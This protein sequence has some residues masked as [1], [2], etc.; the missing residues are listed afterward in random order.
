METT[1]SSDVS[2][3]AGLSLEELE[4]ELASFAAHLAAGMCRWLAVVAEL[5]RR[6]GSTAWRSSAEWIA[7]RCA[8]TPRAAREHVRV[9]RALP[10]LPAIREAFARGELSYAKV[11]ALTRVATAESEAGLLPLAEV[12]TAAQ[13]ER[14]LRVYRRVSTREAREL[15][16]YEELIWY[17]DED[18]ALVIRGRLAPED[19]ALFLKALEA[20]RERLW[21]S[22]Q[23][24]EER[25]SAEPPPDDPPHRPS[26]VDAL[27]ALSD[28]AL[29]LEAGRTGGDRYQVV[30]HIEQTALSGEAG[31]GGCMLDDGPA[32][33]PE[34]ARRLACDAAVVTLY[35]RA[36]EPLSVG[37][38]TRTI[39]PALRRALLTRDHGCRFPGC[40][41]H[42]Y[43]DAHH[44]QHWAQGG[45]TAL[46]NLLL[47]CRRH[48]RLLHEGGYTVDHQLRFHDPWGNEIPP[49]P[50]LP[51][52]SADALRS[53]TA[54]LDITADTCRNGHGDP[55]DLALTI[56]AMQKTGSRD[57][58]GTLEVG[59]AGSALGSD[60][61]GH[62]EREHVHAA[63]TC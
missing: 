20:S 43:V 26:N 27:V 14:A 41:N 51:P 16:D 40:D 54:D 23:P 39:P 22:N 21:R 49:V 63:R 55:M 37:R 48:H 57:V 13:L 34:T 7:Y 42:R 52:G 61:R 9:A 15:Q 4:D 12:L 11:R 58:H 3:F 10:A 19:G 29:A 28:S 46:P 62:R 50:P 8:L 2:E 24:D 33:A 56:D 45:E 18:G 47:L 32:L 1:P 35:E 31:E 60:P 44:I 17:W 6:I 25:G 5:D 36:G 30:I 59:V 53:A 38:K